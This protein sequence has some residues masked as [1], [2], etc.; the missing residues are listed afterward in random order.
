[1][2]SKGRIYFL[3][4]WRGAALLAMIAYHTLYDLYEIFDVE[5]DFRSPFLNAMQLFI[6]SSFIVVAGISAR[7]SSRTMQHGAVVFGAGMLM[8]AGTFIF[9]PKFVI[10]FGVLHFIGLSLMLFSVF[11]KQITKCPG[12][13]LCCIG[14]V[15]FFCFYGLPSR[16]VLFGSVRV[17]DEL[18]VNPPHL[19]FLGLPGSEF[20]SA[21]YFPMIPWFF[22]FLAGTGIG[23]AFH[24]RKIPKFM[25][26]RHSRFLS[27]IGSHT[28]VIYIF[29][30]VA[31]YGILKCVF[32]VI[33]NLK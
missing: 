13:I 12:A 15:L 4:E 29:H 7:L 5:F 6:C 8:T 30:Q 16:T 33:D 10:W 24:D 21:D 31:I 9:L 32:F 2:S 23:E 18:Y 26:E 27:Y 17:P 25:M 11:R 28:L 22:L 20:S 14:L 3:D 19:A 1:M